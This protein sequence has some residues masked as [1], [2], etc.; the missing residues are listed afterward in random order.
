MS[1]PVGFLLPSIGLA[2]RDDPHDAVSLWVA[3]A[4][5]QDAEL[6]AQ[7]Q[8]DEPILSIRIL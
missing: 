6:G 4:D 1:T 2:G 7:A 3:V 8:E 5:H